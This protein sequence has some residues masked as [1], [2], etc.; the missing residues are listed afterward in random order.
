MHESS[1]ILQSTGVL[2]EVTTILNPLK[3][4]FSPQAFIEH[5][6][7]TYLQNG[8]IVNGE[9]FA[10]IVCTVGDYLK[11]KV[12]T[13][14]KENFEG[15]RD[16]FKLFLEH[17][18]VVGEENGKTYSYIGDYLTEIDEHKYTYYQQPF[19]T[20]S[21]ALNNFIKS[22]DNWQNEDFTQ[23]YFKFADENASAGGNSVI[24]FPFQ[25]LSPKASPD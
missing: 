11:E 12:V 17:Q 21:Q 5:L 1:T 9:Y 18:I 16:L 24:N 10:A 6:F 25:H 2:N 3:P 8:D 20:N 23:E 4:E 19:F 13:I 14:L 7:R 15:S 22:I